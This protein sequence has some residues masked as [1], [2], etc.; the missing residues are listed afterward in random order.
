MNYPTCAAARV[1]FNHGRCS[2]NLQLLAE[3]KTFWADIEALKEFKNPLNP[4]S[5]SPSSCV[6]SRDFTLDPCDNLFSGFVHLWL[7]LQPGRQ[8]FVRQ[9]AHRA[10]P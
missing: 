5:V 7:P 2:A 1:T 9:L 3:P 4:D 10:H 8:L 6:S